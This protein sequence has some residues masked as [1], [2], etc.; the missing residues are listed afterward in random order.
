VEP[1]IIEEEFG[2]EIDNVVPTRGYSLI[3][4]V[5]L[6]GSAGGIQAL[7]AF[8]TKMPPD[9]GMVFVVILHLSPEHESIL[10]QMLSRTTTMKVVQA[11]NGEKVAANCVYVIPPGKSIVAMNGHLQLDDLGPGQGRRVV[12][13]IFFRSMADTYGPHSAAIIL[14]GA[15]GDGAIGIKRIKERGGLTIAQDP[16]EAEHPGMPR[17]A[18]ETGMVDWVLEVSQMPSKLI[19]YQEIEKRLRMPPEDGPPPMKP[20]SPTAAE[21]EAVL[22]DVLFFLR[23]KTGRDFSYYKR[24]TVV[25]RVSRRMQVNGIDDLAT[26]LTFLRTHHGEAS[27]LLQDLLISVTNFFRDRA[28]FAA[29]AA[30]IPRLFDGKTDADAV[31]VWVPACATGEEAYS[32]AMLLIEHARTLESPP[33]LHVFGCDLDEAAIKVAREGHYPEAIVAD[34][35]EE[36]LRT[37]FTRD[38]RGYRVR[39]EVRELVLFAAHDLLKD[40]PFSRMNLISCRNLLIY[41]NTDAQRRALEI[42]RF[43]LRSGGLLFLGTSESMPENN[44]AFEVL[45]TKHRLFSHHASRRNGLSDISGSG[46]WL[47]LPDMSPAPVVP[48]QSI[49]PLPGLTPENQAFTDCPSPAELHSRLLERVA[50]PSLIVNGQQDIV[51]LSENAGRFLQHAGGE[52]TTNVLK[53]VNPA[54]RI[55]LRAAL[56]R[57]T[58]TG[59]PVEVCG[60]PVE[61]NGMDHVVDL[62][63]SPADDLA[64]GFILVIFDARRSTGT[65]LAERQT[66]AASEPAVRHLERELDKLRGDLRDTAEQY[67]A[68][69]EELKASNEELQAMNEELRSATEELETSREELQ[70]MNEELLT[71]NQELKENVDELAHANNDLQTLMAAT[72][73]ATVFLDRALHIMRYT[74]PAVELFNLIPGDIGRPLDD[75]KHQLDYPQLPYDARMVLTTLTPVERE[76]SDAAGRWF[77][78]RVSSYRTTEDHI[79]GVVLTFVDF[80]A[81]KSAEDALTE[82]EARFRDLAPGSSPG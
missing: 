21:D 24:G 31:R 39:R 48:W 57:A 75:L 35:S 43:S 23:S 7:Q 77:L 64:E 40:A 42:F 3:P 25:R 70:S 27:A 50:P 5:A 59:K 63:V 46:A 60:L 37:F 49:L 74:P 14:S 58:E 76:V 20:P 68:S 53:L 18:M 54:L 65:E 71:V 28:S 10:A 33:T 29:L 6:G 34:V 72:N 9:T 52:P 81:R 78:V 41:L 45:D 56:F 16:E 32:I 26:Y 44:Q 51:H 2:G 61:I 73:I 66:A 55:E 30:R 12:V 80:T 47:P 17:S 13:D 36:R 8:F 22:R 69:N 1:D 82:S 4:M 11:A 15:D 67:E 79:A 62:R 19:E 38:K